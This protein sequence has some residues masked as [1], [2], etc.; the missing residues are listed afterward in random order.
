MAARQ[1]SGVA[2]SANN[3]SGATPSNK[4]K[5]S[6]LLSQIRTTSHG[7]ESSKDEQY[8]DQMSNGVEVTVIKGATSKNA[9]NGLA[10][11]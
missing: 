2:A 7:A 1:I 6:P 11:S 4:T 10:M 8:G 9:N 5:P 3:S